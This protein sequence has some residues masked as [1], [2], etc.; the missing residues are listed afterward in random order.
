M[1]NRGEMCIF[2]YCPG[3]KGGLTEIS[4]RRWRSAMLQA[5]HAAE[6]EFL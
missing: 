2:I 5:I 6:L 3:G 4:C 1:T